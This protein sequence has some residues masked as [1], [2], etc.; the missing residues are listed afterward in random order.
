MKLKRFNTLNEAEQDIPKIMFRVSVEEMSSN[1]GTS[2]KTVV[3]DRGEADTK[4]GA[5]KIKKD[6][7]KKYELINH[8]GHVVNYKTQ[9]ELF[10]NY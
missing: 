2:K 8:A 1:Y 5:N 10:T 4:E 9:L 6:F 3:V 7:M